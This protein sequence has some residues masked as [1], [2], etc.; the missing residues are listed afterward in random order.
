VADGLEYP[1][2]S[3]FPRWKLRLILRFAEFGLLGN[4]QK[5]APSKP[6]RSLAGVDMTRGSLTVAADPLVPGRFV[7]QAPGGQPGAQTFSPQ[8]RTTSS[9]G[10]TQVLEGV[11]PPQFHLSKFTL[12]TAGSLHTQFPFIACPVDPRA[13]RSVAV[14][15]FLGCIPASDA[16]AQDQGNTRGQNADGSSNQGAA[17]LD[18]LPDTWTDSNGQQRTN[19]RFQGWVDIWEIEWG[20]GLSTIKLECTDNAR[21][22]LNMAAPMKG[23]V[24]KDLPLDQAVA[25]Y[26]T[27][28]PQFAGMSVQ[29]RP[30]GMTAP[31]LASIIHSS[32]FLPGQGPPVSRMGAGVEK[33]SVYDYLTDVVRSVGHSLYVDGTTLVIQRL[34]T[35]TSTSVAQRSDD[36]YVPRQ[37]P[38]GTTLPYRRFIY[39]RNVSSLKLKRNMSG[40]APCN[41]SARAYD[42]DHKRVLVER[43][44]LKKDVV[45]GA[46]GPQVHSLPGDGTTEE[47]WMEFNVP[48]GV[49]DKATMRIFA[50]QIYE[51][52]WRQ[53]MEFDLETKNFSSFGGGNSD[54]DLLDA[55]FGDPLEI[56]FARD[57]F[58]STLGPVQAKLDTVGGTSQLL[59]A[60]GFPAQFADAYAKAYGNSG[61]MQVFRTHRVEI[62]GSVKEGVNFKFDLV[63]YVEVTSDNSLAAGEEPPANAPTQATPSPGGPPPAPHSPPTVGG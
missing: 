53:E 7:L 25:K 26:L 44:P 61:F 36:P 16:M 24:S 1:E 30:A 22:L 55:Q 35:L 18:V 13:L 29:Y 41:V 23:Q 12:R 50:Q 4:L 34:R 40:K 28:S 37:L 5:T 11:V 51:S 33:A 58:Y 17:P 54:P 63:N 57:D 49:V 3:Y 46:P 39:G 31:T 43:Y 6:A 8:S 45:P 52:L 15:F 38:D 14:E 62:G 60:A 2:Q 56:L 59:Q 27:F 21:L 32:A 48:R 19:L 42:P 9:D 20:K 47:K 10:L